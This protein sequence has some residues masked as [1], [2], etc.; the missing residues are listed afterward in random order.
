M[1]FLLFKLYK[2]LILFKC[3]FQA[4][5]VFIGSTSGDQEDRRKKTDDL[6][7]GALNDY[8]VGGPGFVLRFSPCGQ[9]LNLLSL[10][11]Y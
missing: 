8:V 9:I 4:L 5:Q 2:L 6:S 10:S 7:I 11:D 3:F 1:F